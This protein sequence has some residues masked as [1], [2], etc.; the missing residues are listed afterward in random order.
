MSEPDRRDFLKTA[1]AAGLSLGLANAAFA[2]RGARMS[3]RVIGANDRINIGVI[4]VGGRGSY[5]AGVFHHYRREEQQCLPDRGRLRRLRK[6]QE[7][8]GGRSYKCDG[9]LDYREVL[10]RSDIDAVIIAT[11]DHWHAK[12]ALD[13]MD[14]GQGRLPRKAHVPHQRGN[15]AVGQHRARRPSACC[16]WVPRPLPAINGGR[17]KSHRRRH[18]RP[19]DHEPGL[20]PSQFASKANGTGTSTRTPVPTAR[21]TTTSIGRRGSVPRPSAPAMPTASSASANIGITPAASPPTSSITW[22]RR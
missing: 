17:P 18:D 7:G 15:Q 21:A 6:A 11:P 19:D 8:A 9:Y 4:G 12:I 13:A 3:G 20:L 2:A 22:S 16:R 14:H 1:G 5:V 10:D